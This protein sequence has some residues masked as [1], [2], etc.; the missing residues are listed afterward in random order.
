MV[1][2]LQARVQT[3]QE[4]GEKLRL[5]VCVWGGGLLVNKLNCFKDAYT[6]S[7]IC[8]FIL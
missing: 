6:M 1:H 2:E 8:R 7:M 3:E 4:Q 5:Q